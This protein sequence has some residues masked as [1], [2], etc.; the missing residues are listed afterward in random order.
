MV[1]RVSNETIAWDSLSGQHSSAGITPKYSD[2][3][4]PPFLFFLFLSFLPFYLSTQKHDTVQTSWI[5]ETFW[6][7]KDSRFNHD[8]WCFSVSWQPS[9]YLDCSLA[10]NILALLIPVCLEPINALAKKKKNKIN[11]PFLNLKRFK[12]WTDLYGDGAELCYPF[13]ADKKFCYLF[14]F[15]PTAI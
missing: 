9:N 10:C 1:P 12:F 14:P 5:Y 4:L 11:H 8:L 2:I 7:M 13:L 15:L 6:K 3:S